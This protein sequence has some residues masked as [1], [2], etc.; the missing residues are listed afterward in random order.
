MGQ[1]SGRVAAVV[2]DG[3]LAEQLAGEL[4]SEGADVRRALD[5]LHR[6]D[7]L[8]DVSVPPAVATPFDAM[9]VDQWIA[10]CEA[11]MLA[12]LDLLRRAF[13]LLRA[14]GRGRVVLVTPTIALTGAAGLAAGA[15]GA[16]GRRALGKSA[17]RRWGRF[18]ITVN[19]LAPGTVEADD[20]LTI[21]DPALDG[22]GAPGPA[23]TLLAGDGAGAFTGQT[24]VVDG[25]VW[26]PA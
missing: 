14:S 17:A 2:G 1:L 13:P 16:E 23:A 10:E 19:F 26:M 8:V 12:T 5:R 11:P 9:G 6:L 7:S 3:A 18:G 24:I 4:A 20:R 21:A 22:E 15:A 25:G